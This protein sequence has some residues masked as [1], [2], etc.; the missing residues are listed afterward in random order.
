[1]DYKKDRFKRHDEHSYRDSYEEK[2]YKKSF[3]R[4][5][6]RDQR[7]SSSRNKYE[8]DWRKPGGDYNRDRYQNNYSRNDYRDDRRNDNRGN[9]GY[10]GYKDRGYGNDRSYGNN[11]GYGDRSYNERSFTPMGKGSELGR[12]LKDVNW[13]KTNLIPFK[14]DFYNELFNPNSMLSGQ[15]ADQFRREKEIFIK[16]ANSDIPAPITSFCDGQVRLPDYLVAPIK[17]ANF[18]TPTAIQS[19]AWPIVFSG[20]DLIGIAETGSGKTLAYIAPA[21]VH[22]DNQPAVE[23][24]EGP[25]ALILAPTREL[26]V[27]IEGE[28]V[29]FGQDARTSSVAVFGGVEKYEQK[30]KLQRGVDLLVA[31]P[32]RL[33]DFLEMKVLTLNRVT[34]LILDEADRMLDMGFE[35]QIRKIINQIRPDRQT[36]MFSATWPREVQCL[37]RDLCYNSPCHI[38]IGNVELT[39][40]QNIQQIVH[41]V[42]ERCKREWLVP[43]LFDIIGQETKTLIFCQ[44]K[45]NCEKISQFLSHNKLSC[46]AIHGDKTQKERDHVLHSFKKSNILFLVATDVAARGLDVH[47]VKCVLNYDFPLNIEDYVHRIGRTGRAGKKGVAYSFFS[48]DNEKMAKQLIGIMREAKQEVPYELEEL[49]DFRKKRSAPMLINDAYKRLVDKTPVTTVAKNFEYDHQAS[50]KSA[51]DSNNGYSR[52]GYGND[53]KYDFNGWSGDDRNGNKFNG[54]Y[55]RQRNNGYNGGGFSGF[56]TNPPQFR[57]TFSDKNNGSKIGF[58]NKA[59]DSKDPGYND[60]WNTQKTDTRHANNNPMVYSSH[61][62][63]QSQVPQYSI[64]GANGMN[65]GFY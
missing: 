64:N 58:F 1:M 17:R 61:M 19:Q 40:N 26:A 52:G 21:I 8:D 14:K 44:T 65:R 16:A 38:Q 6:K 47:D 60:S 12:N 11:R 45:R 48:E 9:G 37:A 31:T 42:P 57:S 39:S 13:N 15:E 54:G 55:D 30:R 56:S 43:V 32:G 41:L 36:C 7:H 2:R 59:M 20:K 29:K 23:R 18:Q 3:E 4:E 33:I 34:M 62:E 50:W 63:S 35:P 49:G 46:M 51:M 5:S 53:R 10:N 24:G 25:I 28:C 27:Q 22:I